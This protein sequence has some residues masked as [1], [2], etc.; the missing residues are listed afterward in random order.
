VN[1]IKKTLL[2]SV[3]EVYVNIIHNANIVMVHFVNTE[4]QN[5]C[6]ECGSGI[7]E[8]KKKKDNVKNEVKVIHYANME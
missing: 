1:T 5:K 2:K 6:K 8:R 7:C 3:K 4:N